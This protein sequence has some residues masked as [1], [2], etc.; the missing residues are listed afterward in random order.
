[1]SGLNNTFCGAKPTWANACV[2]NNGNPN[3][4]TYTKGFPQAAN[5]M[6]K[7][8]L[9]DRGRQLS[10]DEYIYP[11]CFNMRHSVELG[12]GNSSDTLKI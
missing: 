12:I 4:W 5:L 6:I 7:A 1:V 2:G 9:L 10:V 11:V 3:Y 8:V